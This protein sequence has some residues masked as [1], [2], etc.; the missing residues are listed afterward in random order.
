MQA[1]AVRT[2]E[3]DMAVV[4]FELKANLI[5]V[6]ARVNDQPAHLIFDTGAS[7]TVIDQRMAERAGIES[8]ERLRARGA[9]GDIDVSLGTARSISVGLAA[10]ADLKCIVSDLAGISEKLGGGIDGVLGFDFNARYRITIDYA[11]RELTFTRLRATLRSAPANR[12][13]S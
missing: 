10:A 11:L 8:S 7:Q 9:G 2:S 5:V 3:E 12:C 1:E 4:P 13:K 6:D